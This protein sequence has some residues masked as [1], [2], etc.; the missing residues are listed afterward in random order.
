MEAAVIASAAIFADV[1]ASDAIPV[2]VSQFDVMAG[3]FVRVVTVGITAPVCVT[4]ANVTSPLD[5]LNCAVP[6]PLVMRLPL[7]VQAVAGSAVNPA[8]VAFTTS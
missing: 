3:R 7:V 2:A 1:I 6:V 5:T 4:P 8:F